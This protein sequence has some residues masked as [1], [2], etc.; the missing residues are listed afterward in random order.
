MQGR[1][2]ENRMSQLG[3]QVH[4]EEETRF[5]GQMWMSAAGVPELSMRWPTRF[6]PAPGGNLGSV[7]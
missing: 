7:T 1:A 6:T 4:E 5:L 2:D 3:N